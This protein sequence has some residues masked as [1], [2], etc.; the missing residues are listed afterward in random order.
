M[1]NTMTTYEGYGRTRGESLIS[2]AARVR[3]FHA[4][5]TLHERRERT[6]KDPAVASCSTQNS[7]AAIYY[8]WDGEKEHLVRF[9]TANNRIRAYIT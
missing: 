2:L 8:I 6:G 3:Y 7:H 4:G 1:G 9:T 5:T